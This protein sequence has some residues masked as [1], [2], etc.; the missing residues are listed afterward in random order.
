M[1]LMKK[2][3]HFNPSM[4]Y[5]SRLIAAVIVLQALSSLSAQE[6]P[7]P[8]GASMARL[9]W[10]SMPGVSIQGN[11]V[12]VRISPGSPVIRRRNCALSKFDISPFQ[13]KELGISILMRGK[14]VSPS[15]RSWNY[16]ARL[17][18]SYR[19]LNGGIRW[20]EAAT[21]TGDFDWTRVVLSD[22]IPSGAS[23]GTIYLGLDNGS[24]EVE[25]DLSTLK[26]AVWDETA[27]P[28]ETV[29]PQA[30]REL[31]LIESRMR[32]A[33][34]SSRTKPKNEV[35]ALLARQ[36]T[37]GTF[38]NIDYNDENRSR[39][40]TAEHLSQTRAIARAYASKSHPLYRNAPLGRAIRNAVNWWSSNRPF[41]SNWWW[42]DMWVPE[43][44]GE[45]LLLVPDLFPQ[46]PE[47]T[48]ALQVCR[49]AKFLPRY[50]GNNRVYIAR[51]IFLRALLE[52]NIRPL[53]A[54]ASA[55]TEEIRFASF[56]NKNKDGFGGIRADG[57]YHL[58]GPQVQFGNYG[59]EFLKNAAYWANIWQ[60]TQWQF[61]PHQWNVIHHLAFNG[62]R[63]ILWHGKM[64]LLACGRQLGR[65]AAATKG[66]T[67]LAALRLL[68][69]AD[70]GCFQTYDEILNQSRNNSLIGN[71]HF[72]N[73]DYMVHRR[74]GWYAAV[75]MN[76]VRVRPIEDGINW[77]NSLGRY[78]SDGVCLIYR[79]GKEYDNITAVW[80]WTRLPGTTL[81]ATP[82]HST[83][84]LRWTLRPNG[85]SR[86]LGETEFVGGVT[87]GV[88]GAAVFTM[89]LDGVKAKKAYFFDTDAIYQLGADISSTSPHEVATTVNSCIRNGE[90][91]QQREWFHHDGIG[92]RGKGLIL[93]TGKRTGDWRILEGGLSSPRMET[94]DVFHLQINHGIKPQEASY[95]FAILPGATPE[96]TANWRK[97]KVL[98]NTG[99]IQAIEFNDGTIGAIFHEPG[100]LGN[101]Q[102]SAP[103][104]FLIKGN[105][106]IAVDPTARLQKM[107]LMLDGIS[108]SIGLP[109]GEK[110]G[111]GVTVKF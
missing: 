59:C 49:Q 33:L 19:M 72:W 100:K 9:H 48:A 44:L 79:T 107:N 71:H 18:L 38:E 50:T 108:K 51:N 45:T 22:W 6:Q 56:E 69:K 20:V 28:P 92:Y 102:T 21:P 24:G 67:T 82:V 77:D 8:S 104:A 36:R 94:R 73:S 47:R 66:K 101:F 68:R 12:L 75:R 90:I 46:G 5:K 95:C 41:N 30:A 64:D 80:D 109:T 17:L 70:P 84:Q 13:N 1:K 110:G 83:K 16:N 57:C 103:G 60:D 52:R 35:L 76:S 106:V 63:W 98:S 27:E 81:P 85:K 34:L 4:I 43:T 54:A 99:A 39:W 23:D 26:I 15:R 29:S 42:N 86:Q 93:S 91:R 87:D 78:F 53:N 31:D 7:V 105:S 65:N 88:R 25:F 3:I 74:P 10:I 62:F 37:D 58:H 96:E 55:L 40:K 89:N 97:G 2:P 111:T 11:R 32:N 14:N 61:S